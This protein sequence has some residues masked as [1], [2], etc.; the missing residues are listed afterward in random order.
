MNVWSENKIVI[1]PFFFFF[2]S[3]CSI[4]IKENSSLISTKYLFKNNKELDEEQKSYCFKTGLEW[5]I[6]P[7]FRVRSDFGVN[8]ND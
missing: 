1:K 6:N 3:L 8:K 7:K 5:S 4:L 2:L